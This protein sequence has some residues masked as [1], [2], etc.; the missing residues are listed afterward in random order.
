MTGSPLAIGG[1][2]AMTLAGFLLVS[3]PGGA[4]ADAYERRRVLLLTQAGMGATS[5]ALTVLALSGSPPLPALYLIAFLAAAIA[6]VDGPTRRAMIPVSCRRRGSRQRTCWIRA[7]RN[8]R[9]WWGPPSA[10]SSSRPWVCRRPTC[11]TPPP[12]CVALGAAIVIS[13]MPP[14]LGAPAAGDGRPS[15][16]ASASSVAPRSSWGP[17]SSTSRRWSSASRGPVPHPGPGD[18]PRGSGHPGA[19]DGRAGRGSAPRHADRG[20]G[21]R[22]A[23]SGSGG[24]RRG[25]RLGGGHLRL[26]AAGRLAAPGPHVPGRGRR[27]RRP[28]RPVPH[29]DHPGRHAGRPARPRRRAAGSLRQW[30]APRRRH[31]GDGGGGG[32]SGRSC[33]P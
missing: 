23:P 1:L 33:P 16:M 14:A 31:R 8:S 20:L 24:H 10:G 15:S 19:P 7:V 6:S 11:S 13:P 2:A 5:L 30:R 4:I 22:G 12:S 28:Q 3:L 29:H 26:R 25:R 21:R 9:V 32:R 27:G 18:L 17:S